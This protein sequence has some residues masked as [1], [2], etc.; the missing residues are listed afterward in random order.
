MKPLRP[1]RRVL[2]IYPPVYD[3]RFVDTMVVPPMGIMYLAAFVRDQVDVRLLDAVVED[4]SHR[5]PAANDMELVGLGYDEIIRRVQQFQPDLV[6][7]SCIFSSQM[8]SIRQLAKRIKTEVD[9]DMVLVAGGTHPSFLPEQTLNSSDLD[10]IVLGEGELTFRGLIDAHNRGTG[11]E[12]L[13]GIAYRD[14]GRVEVHPRTRWVENLDD[15][16]F[17]ARDLLP[18]EDYFRYNIPMLL[19]WKKRRNTPIITSR[20]CPYRCT[21]CSSTAHWGHRFRPRS[22]DNVLAEIQHLRDTYN[23]QELKFQDDNLTLIKKRAQAIFQ[24]M[25]DR[26]L[27]MPWNT[28][29]GVAIWT[30]DE[31]LIRT[32]KQSGCY[33][34][35]LAL[36]S[37]DPEVL[38]N[39]I[40]KPVDLDEAR[41]VVRLCRK[42]KISPWANVIIG[43]PGETLAQVHNTLRFARE[44]KLDNLLPF[45]FNPLPGSQLW[46]VCIDQGYLPRDYHYEE[47][48]NF[49]RSDLRS[50]QFTTRQ[51]SA[52]QF[53]SYLVNV[54]WRPI[55]CPWMFY[56]YYPR[57]LLS[58]PNF[59]RTFILLLGKFLGLLFKSAPAP[60]TR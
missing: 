39:I 60:G 34:L 45:I 14:G 16:P 22:P 31:E 58:R 32:M 20:G 6:G 1:I 33:H 21:F 15:L 50:D 2:L 23:V 29:N 49:G 46:D 27:A 40:N 26:G 53:K 11:L 48:N 44:L 56:S 52:L 35:C 25:I 51:L 30:L 55:R 38:K 17:P 5:V 59:L 28:P 37:G 12:G 9:P 7:F 57:L 13:D 41:E 54:L 36:E 3:I 24:G 19:I 8:Q 47:A 42:Y 10:Y 43:F 4:P 18:M